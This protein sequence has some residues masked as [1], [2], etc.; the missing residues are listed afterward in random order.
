MFLKKILKIRHTLAFRLTL[1]YASTFTLSSFGA[2]LIFYIII[3]S[4]IQE[5]TDQGLLNDLAEF[6]SILELKGDNSLAAEMN[7][8]AESD[9]EGKIFF[10]LLDPKGDEIA[11]SNM[12]SWRGVGIGRI[13]LTRVL[14]GEHH[15]FE[16]L[17]WQGQPHKARIVYGVIGPGKIMQIGRSLE[18]DA[19]FLAAFREVFGTSMIGIMFF[20][21]LIGWFM[22]KRALS[23]VEEVTQAALDISKGAFDRRVRVR[24]KGDEIVQ[25]ATVFNRMLDRIYELVT[26]MREVT[27]NIAHDL[28]T[29]VARIRGL[30]ESELNA[31]KSNDNSQNLAADIIEECD[32]LLQM[33]DTMLELS[34]TEAGVAELAKEKV[35]I[36][37]VIQGACELFSPI[38]ENKSVSLISK[39]ANRRFV[40]G[41]IRGLQRMIVN[42]L[43]NAIKYTRPGGTVTISIHDADDQIVIAVHDTGVGISKDDL[44]HIFKRLYRCD[45]SRSQPG[46]GLGLSLAVAIAK[47][48][49][50]D[51]TVTSTPG[52][53]SIF[54]VNLPSP[55]F[56]A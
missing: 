36:V 19:R 26:G 29:P 47:A 49:G 48:H 11:S 34:E 28:K 52:E 54:T 3:S 2:F 14:G 40:S 30:A 6:S 12:S 37:G 42:L 50:G 23:D 5:R 16:T 22:A 45:T 18:D 32:Y 44:P 56:S 13:A 43:E 53:G 8:E 51:I 9:G 39:A 1:W 21:A 55:P 31:G 46:F 15:A 33:I 10:R 27:D 17:S 7:I 35:D 41:D 25:L 24:A 38:A 4:I 20:A